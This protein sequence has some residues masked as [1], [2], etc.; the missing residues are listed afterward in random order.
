MTTPL[1]T[2][3]LDGLREI[4]SYSPTLLARPSSLR[5]QL[6][7]PGATAADIARAVALLVARG[8]VQRVDGGLR[9]GPEAAPWLL[10]GVWVGAHVVYVGITSRT[11]AEREAE[12]WSGEQAIDHY[13]RQ[14]RD[15]GYSVRMDV[16]SDAPD[17][18]T[19]RRKESLYIRAYGLIARAEGFE[20]LNG[21][22][23]GGP[24]RKW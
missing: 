1:E 14:A 19:A 2:R 22:P 15:Q 10:Y 24:G 16:L 20:M 5:D 6:H 17:E 7:L 8:Q 11:I 12:H 23:M 13:M 9:V 4:Q 3:V 21:K 18:Q